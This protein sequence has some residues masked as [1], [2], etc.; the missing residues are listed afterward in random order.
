VVL[1][2]NDNSRNKVPFLLIMAI[3]WIW[4]F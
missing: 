4:R 2:N 1:I 3:N